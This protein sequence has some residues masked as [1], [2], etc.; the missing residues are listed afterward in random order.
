VALAIDP[1][2]PTVAVSATGGVVSKTIT[3][4]PANAAVVACTTH[5]TTAGVL[6]ASCAITDDHSLSWTQ[7]AARGEFDTGGNAGLATLNWARNGAS[8]ATIAVTGTGTNVRGEISMYL[9]VL[10]GAKLTG[11]PIG[12][13]TEHSDTDA[14]ALSVTLTTTADGS[15]VFLVNSDWWASTTYTYGATVTNDASGINNTNNGYSY[16]HQTA[17]V[18]SSG[19]SVTMSSTNAAATARNNA[20][21]FEVLAEPAGAGF[22]RPT[23]VV[24]PSMAV[25]RAGSW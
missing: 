5:N 22:V 4:C 23:I 12:A 8:T 17:I 1:S 9:W 14:S 21:L 16:A 18:T 3:N 15:L 13:I 24:A 20:I 25:Q 11:S 7:P 10:T 19:T 6:T 2:T